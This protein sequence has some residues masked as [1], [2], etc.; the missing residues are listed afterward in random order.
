MASL[1]LEL[2][3]SQLNGLTQLAVGQGI[4]LEEYITSSL[5]APSAP[6]SGNGTVPV[7]L[8]T[9]ITESLSRITNTVDTLSSSVD[10]RLKALEGKGGSAPA[11]VSSKPLKAR[12]IVDRSASDS[13]ASTESTWLTTKQ[14]YEQAQSQG[15][16]GSRVVFGNYLR[17]WRKT[18]QLPT[19][20]ETINLVHAKMD[21]KD[22]DPKARHL[23]WLAFG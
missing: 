18:R 14:A 4:S 15:F 1:L 21:E 19:Q 6:S 10:E 11:S 23:A 2:S 22:A 3:P 12:S 16:K 9:E 17:E 7:G 13:S 20:L 8:L 5:S